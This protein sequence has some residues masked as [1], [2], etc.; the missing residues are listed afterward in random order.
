LFA[1]IKNTYL[2]ELSWRMCLVWC[3]HDHW[4]HS[5]HDSCSDMVGFG[6]CVKCVMMHWLW[7]GLVY[8]IYDYSCH[9]CPSFKKQ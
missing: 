4:D 3:L 8:T 7:R 9:L 1:L 2:G 5:K 6:I